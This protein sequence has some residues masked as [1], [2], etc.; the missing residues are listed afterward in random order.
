MSRVMVERRFENQP[1]FDDVQAQEEAVAWCF[2][3]H[4]VKFIRSYFSK[5]R[6]TMICEYEAPDAEAVRMVQR[7][8]GVPYERIWTAEVFEW[9]HQE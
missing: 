7:T 8:S 1:D 6:R 2:S 5:D 4:R 3:Q 9:D